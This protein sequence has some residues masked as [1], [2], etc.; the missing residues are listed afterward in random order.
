MH[1]HT[2]KRPYLHHYMTFY[3][4]YM[5]RVEKAKKKAEANLEELHK[6]F[7]YTGKGKR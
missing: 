3:Y 1:H 4:E 6:K 5:P 7:R 2:F